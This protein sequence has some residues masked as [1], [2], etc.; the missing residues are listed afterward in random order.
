MRQR[1]RCDVNNPRELQSLGVA[2]NLV[3]MSIVISIKHED[4]P[5]SATTIPAW[6]Y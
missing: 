1:V 3:E 2:L 6:D 5:R 4:E